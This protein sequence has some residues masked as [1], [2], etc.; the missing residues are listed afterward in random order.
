MRF[1]AGAILIVLSAM[2]SLLYAHDLFVKLDTYFVNPGTKVRIPVMNGTFKVSENAVTRDRIIDI[3]VVSLGRREHIDTTAWIP[4]G[5]TTY[6][7]LEAAGSGTYVVGASTHPRDLE[8]PA[9]DFN[10]Y[11]EHDGVADVLEARRRD[12]ELGKD[13]VERYHK[14]VKAVFQVGD[15]RTEDFGA[16]LGYPAE[17]IPLDSP[18]TLRVGADFRVRCLV[19]GNAVP[20]Q[21]VIAG[22]EGASGAIEARATRTD[23]DGVARFVLDAPGKWYVK[24]INMLRSPEAGVDYESKWG[25]LTFEVR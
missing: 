7:Q 17:I 3:S 4:R 24:F 9:E 16:A 1:R 5:D 19:N 2:A 10:E 11:L 23:A 18:Y 12:G 14:H 13:V 20:N 22:G 21:L 15:R 8:L 6:L 25:T